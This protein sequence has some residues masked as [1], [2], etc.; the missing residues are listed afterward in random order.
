MTLTPISP[1]LDLEILREVALAPEDLF[2]GWTDPGTLM[3][4]F[5]PRPWRVVECEID[6]RPGGMFATTMQGPDGQT[7]PRGE[8]CWLVVEP[9]HRLVWTNMLGA[10][11]RPRHN[12]APGFD[13]VCDLRFE[14]LPNGMTRYHA[15]VMHAGPEGKA[16][17]EAMGFEQGWSTALA[18]LVDLKQSGE[19]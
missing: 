10:N 2:S 7:M 18:Q 1:S 5:C 19:H 17:H 8:G 16:L 12:P 11:F 15:R 6:L 13:F 4:W 9:P 14:P 3:K